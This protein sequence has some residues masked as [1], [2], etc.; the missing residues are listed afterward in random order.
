MG[1]GRLRIVIGAAAAVAAVVAIA[2]PGGSTG[3][4]QTQA[5]PNRQLQIMAPAAPGGGWGTTARA[6]ESSARDAKLDDGIEAW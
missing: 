6:F 5:Y 2:A 4:D 1:R 3:D